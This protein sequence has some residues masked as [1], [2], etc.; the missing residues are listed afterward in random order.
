MAHPHCATVEP[1]FAELCNCLPVGL[2]GISWIFRLDEQGRD[3]PEEVGIVRFC[4]EGLTIECNCLEPIAAAS[5]PGSACCL[6]KD[7]MLI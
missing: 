4:L 1:V 6:T 7:L 3:L 5:P 2:A